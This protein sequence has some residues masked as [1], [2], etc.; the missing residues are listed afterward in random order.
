MSN[1]WTHWPYSGYFSGKNSAR[2]PWLAKCQL[3][4]PSL[5]RKTPTAEIPTN[6]RLASDGSTTMEC[7]QSPPA[8]TFLGAPCRFVC[9]ARKHPLYGLSNGSGCCH[10]AVKPLRVEEAVGVADLQEA[11]CEP[12]GIG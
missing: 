7:R 12:H 6:I 2:V 8:A 10:G 11:V 3:A 1:L 5:V 9:G 4:P